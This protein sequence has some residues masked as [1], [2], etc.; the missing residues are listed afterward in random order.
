M[1]PGILYIITLVMEPTIPVLPCSQEVYEGVVIQRRGKLGRI[2]YGAAEEMITFHQ[3]NALSTEEELAN[4]AK[5]KFQ[6]AWIN[7]NGGMKTTLF[8]IYSIYLN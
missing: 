2:Q 7:F 1:R 5:V 8:F 3:L 6:L 4:G